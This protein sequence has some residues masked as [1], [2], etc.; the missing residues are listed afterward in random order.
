MPKI[1]VSETL[2]F[3]SKQIYDIVVDVD[4]YPKFLPWCVNARTYDREEHQFMAE[5]TVAFQGIRE[6]FT[7]LDQ[8]V[9]EKKVIINLRSGPF[10]YLASTWNFTPENNQTRVDF[11]IDFRFQSRLKEMIVGPVFSIIS[12]QMLQ[13]FCKRAQ[14][15]Y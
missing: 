4:S 12:K 14:S 13:A 7:T 11:F 1:R 5:M 9:P 15:I 10:Q 8:V 2:P 3:T 6:V